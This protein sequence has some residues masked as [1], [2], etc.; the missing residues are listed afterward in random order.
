MKKCIA[1]LALVT[2]LVSTLIIPA[3]A[4]ERK[5][6]MLNCI[7]ELETV[8]GCKFNDDYVPYL[9]DGETMYNADDKLSYVDHKTT[10]NAT[11]VISGEAPRYN[12]EGET[13]KDDS[14]YLL[15]TFF[16]L[17]KTYEIGY[18]MKDNPALTASICSSLKTDEAGSWT[19]AYSLSNL[20]CDQKL[21]SRP[22]DG[23]LDYGTVYLED[24]FPQAVKA[25]YVAFGLTEGRCQHADQLAPRTD[26]NPNTSSANPNYFRLTELEFYEGAPL[27]PRPLRAL[28]C[29]P[30]PRLPRRLLPR[31][32]L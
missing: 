25:K 12:V 31:I 14:K 30:L 6:V 26:L 29:R 2:L 20:V 18:M 1:V 19:V 7:G 27:A 15:V 16:E 4:A 11:A 10:A 23:T 17:D 21:K 9:W 22:A 24:E 28:R 32:P 5:N 13:G 8:I 3:S